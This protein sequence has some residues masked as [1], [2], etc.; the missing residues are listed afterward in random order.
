MGE[1]RRKCLMAG[2]LKM[3]VGGLRS[4]SRECSEKCQVEELYS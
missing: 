4:R 3:D 2:I 1:K